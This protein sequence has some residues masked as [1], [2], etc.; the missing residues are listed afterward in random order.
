[1]KS[2]RR[3]AAVYLR[4]SSYRR[5][6]R[7]ATLILNSSENLPR[8]QITGKFMTDI[9]DERRMARIIIDAAWYRYIRQIILNNDRA[10]P[11]PVFAGAES[12]D[13]SDTGG[14]A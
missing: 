5:F 7:L 4:T 2:E 11:A 1:M 6:P 13:R 14:A 9:I 3:F 12:K 10:E 8:I